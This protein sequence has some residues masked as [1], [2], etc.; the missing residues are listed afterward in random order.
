[1]S[2]VRIESLDDALS[3]MIALGRG[4]DEESHTLADDILIAVIRYLK[5]FAWGDETMIDAIITSYVS[6]NKW[7]A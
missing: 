7:Y 1:M 2:M 3:R 5:Q 4:P 6:I